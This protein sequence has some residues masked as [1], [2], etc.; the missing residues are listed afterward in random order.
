MD[1]SGNGVNVSCDISGKGV[2]VSCDISGKGVNVPPVV[3]GLI[4]LPGLCV[5]LGERSSQCPIMSKSPSPTRASEWSP[6][7]TTP[8]Q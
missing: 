6:L 4:S 1:I 3:K 8:S 7:A 2:N 5:C